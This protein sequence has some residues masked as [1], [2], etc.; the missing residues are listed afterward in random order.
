MF[1]SWNGYRS[2]THNF[3]IEQLKAS[4]EKVEKEKDERKIIWIMIP[5]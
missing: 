4:P 3:I 1:M 2:F 5:W